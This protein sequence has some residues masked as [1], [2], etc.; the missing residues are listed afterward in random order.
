MPGVDEL[1]SGLNAVAVRLRELGDEGLA[2]EL[3]TAVERAVDPL[4]D[5]IPAALRPHLPDRYADELGGELKV[6]RS[7]SLGAAGDIAQ[8]TV[9][10]SVTGARK[11][12]LAQSDAGILWHPLFG[13]FP[14]RDPR[15]RW[16][17]NEPPSVTPGWFSDPVEESVPV[18][19][20]AVEQ[21][22]DNVVEKAVGKGL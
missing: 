2:R 1:A 8:V 5:S 22:L 6:R 17:Q 13:R 10:A 19:R 14:Y 20:D 18:I 11:R 9:L 3:Q 15:N 4:K 16:F 21:A 7:T 12:K